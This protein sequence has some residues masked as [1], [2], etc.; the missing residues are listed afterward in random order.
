MHSIHTAIRQYNLQFQ[1]AFIYHRV[2]FQEEL[3][4]FQDNDNSRTNYRLSRTCINPP[5]CLL[6][7]VFLTTSDQSASIW[8]Q[9]YTINAV[10][11]CHYWGLVDC[12]G[13]L[14]VWLT[15]EKIPRRHDPPP[16]PPLIDATVRNNFVGRS[17]TLAALMFRIVFPT[18]FISNW[19]GSR[20]ERKQFVP[21]DGS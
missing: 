6:L 21:S 17:Q 8:T 4:I 1:T 10:L 18:L 3:P 9:R 20:R 12:C 5:A 11:R 7:N 14:A 2:K 13:H 15:G 16:R 19:P